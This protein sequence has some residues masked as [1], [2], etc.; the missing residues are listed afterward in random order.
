MLLTS[1][2]QVCFGYRFIILNKSEN[3]STLQD[4]HGNYGITWWYLTNDIKTHYI[5]TNSGT[6]TKE[7]LKKNPPHTQKKPRI[8]DID[9]NVLPASKY[10]VNTFVLPTQKSRG[11]KITT[12]PRV[13]AFLNSLCECKIELLQ[14]RGGGDSKRGMQLAN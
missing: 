12:H 1:A 6:H 10:T 3:R 14:K 9:S 7:L 5:Q 13:S 4:D 11:P 8:T 2:M